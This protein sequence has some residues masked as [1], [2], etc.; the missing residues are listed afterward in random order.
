MLF[1]R[2][3]APRLHRIS[4]F[5]TTIQNRFAIDA[6]PGSCPDAQIEELEQKYPG[7]PGLN[8][9]WEVREGLAKHFSAYDHPARRPGFEARCSS[10]EAQV[11]NLADEIAYYSHDLDDGLDSGLLTEAR[12]RRDVHLWRD[13]DRAVR[14]QHGPLPDECRRYFIIRCL[15]DGQ[16][17]DVVQT[18]ESRIAAARVMPSMTKLRELKLPQAGKARMAQ[19]TPRRFQPW[20]QGSAARA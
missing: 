5:F 8:L 19:P 10:L 1:S 16:V 12:L 7:F 4:G 11:A 9:S 6:L 17:K 3:P 13:A 14:K 15:I 2:P 18:T 20:T